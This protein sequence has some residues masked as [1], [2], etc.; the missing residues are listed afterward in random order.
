MRR[1]KGSSAPCRRERGGVSVLRAGLLSGLLT[2][3]IASFAAAPANAQINMDSGKSAAQIFATTCAACHRSAREIRPTSASF[4][5]EHYTA[6]RSEAAA[7]AAYLA[8]VGSDPNAV[9]QRPRPALGVGPAAQP[10]RTANGDRSKETQAAARRPRRPAD[11]F[12]VSKLP[13]ADLTETTEAAVPPPPPPLEPI[14]E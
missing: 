13:D 5:R 2:G 3:V 9:K 4:L 11:S 6:G 14:E 10:E 8:A 7:M 12:E 1:K